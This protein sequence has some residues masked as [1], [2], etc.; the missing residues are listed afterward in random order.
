LLFNSIEFALFLVVA[1]L[2]YYVLSHK[3]QNIFLIAASYFFYGWWDWRFC[4]LLTFIT[5]LNYYCALNTAPH[6][7]HKKAFLYAG[8]AGSLGALGFFKYYN[9]FSDSLAELFVRFGLAAPFPTLHIILP[10]GIS[11]Y[12]FQSMAYPIDVYRGKIQATQ[13]ILSAIAF[14]TFFPQ[15]L[16]GPIERADRMIPQFQKPRIVDSQLIASGMLLILIGLFKKIAVADAVSPEV[17]NVF[18]HVA[19]TPWPELI[20]GLWLYTIQIYCDFSGYSDIARGVGRLFGFEIMLNFN[21]PYFAANI[22]EFWR[23]WHISLSTWLRDYLY[24]P[25]GGSRAGVFKTYRNLMLTMVLCGLWHGA[26]WTFVAWGA[27]HGLYLC[28]YR[29]LSGGA[30]KTSRSLFAARTIKLCSIILTV[31]LVALAWLF[32]RAPSLSEAMVYL[33][34]IIQLRGTCENYL[35]FFW[36]IAFYIG[37]VLLID[38]PQYFRNDHTAML[39]W[40]WVLRGVICGSMIILMILLAPANEM[41]FIYFQF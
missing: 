16:S 33:K 9:F 13:D 5:L 11:F 28:G 10:V 30:G 24:I 39:E 25:L 23:R 36:R 38:I 22:G 14:M 26:N 6:C 34:G 29:L 37:L 3:A 19:T 8:I 27:L 18:S 32:F 2:I 7:R 12:T 31:N 17:N 40:P 35:F 21:H 4:G 41:P 1:L 20:G 15:L